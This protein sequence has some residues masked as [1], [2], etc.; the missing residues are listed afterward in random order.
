MDIYIFQRIEKKYRITEAQRQQL[1]EMTGSYLIPDSHGRNT[2]CSLYLD[3]PDRLLI[4]NSID[5]VSYKEKLRL[6]SYGV[7]RPDTQVFLEIKKKYQG[8]VYKR[9]VSMPLRD[10]QSYIDTGRTDDHS[11]IMS[12]IEYAMDFYHRPKASMMVA[13]EREAYFVKDLPN[14]RLTFDSGVRYRE[15]YL[16]L[17]LGTDGIRILEDGSYILEIKTDGAMPLWLAS[18]LDRCGI[19]PVSYS[20]YANSYRDALQIQNSNFKGELNHVRHF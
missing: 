12:E 3:T 9:R 4:R 10:A 14:V 20:K 18:A 16:D 17:S 11:Q 2:I 8:V 6:R 19:Y 7:P 1:M 5:A 13:Y 15:D